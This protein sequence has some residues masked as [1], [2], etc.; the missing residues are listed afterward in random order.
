[1]PSI[2]LTVRQKTTLT[3]LINLYRETDSVVVTAEN[4]AKEANRNPGTIRNQMQELKSHQLVDGIAG[5]GGGYMPTSTAY[6]VLDIDKMRNHEAIP[7]KH[8]GDVTNIIIESI[9][10][11]TIRHPNICRAKIT[12]RGSI[13]DFN[14]G[15]KIIIGP[16]PVSKL[17]ITGIIDAKDNINGLLLLHVDNM[18]TPNVDN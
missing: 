6:D 1:M 14:T 7:V 5:P 10:F 17:Q 3:I 16:S 2:E 18:I 9:K 8:N 4:I 13:Q 11:T 12:L 15:D